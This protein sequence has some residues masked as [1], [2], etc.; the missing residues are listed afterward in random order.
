[1]FQLALWIFLLFY[2]KL[3]FESVPMDFILLVFNFNLCKVEM[4]HGSHH[5]FA[6]IVNWLI[7]IDK[8]HYFIFIWFMCF[9]VQLEW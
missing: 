5:R 4:I 7:I 3:F 1:M 2:F 8:K 6:I 9:H